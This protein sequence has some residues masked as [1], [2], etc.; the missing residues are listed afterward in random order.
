MR[1]ASRPAYG[2][3]LLSEEPVSLVAAPSCSVANMVAVEANRN[4]LDGGR[5]ELGVRAVVDVRR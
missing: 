5:G 1:R 3:S 4:G 2:R